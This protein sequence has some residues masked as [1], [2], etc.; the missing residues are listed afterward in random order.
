MWPNSRL[1]VALGA[2]LISMA[3][4]AYGQG[5]GVDPRKRTGAHETMAVT[6]TGVRP[7]AGIDPA[8]V[9]VGSD[10]GDDV[11]CLQVVEVIDRM[12]ACQAQQCVMAFPSRR[13]LTLKQNQRALLASACSADSAYVKPTLL[14]GSASVL[15]LQNER[16][17]PG[18]WAQERIGN[19]NAARMETEGSFGTLTWSAGRF[20]WMESPN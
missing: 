12:L 19:A 8:T 9:R 11:R 5:T 4:A 2:V 1:G 13:S 10:R 3:L 6:P 20:V 17:G 7:V 15:V 18:I 16:K 14:W